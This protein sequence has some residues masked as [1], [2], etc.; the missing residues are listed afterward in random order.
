MAAR[1]GQYCTFFGS[2]LVNKGVGVSPHFFRP[3]NAPLKKVQ[4]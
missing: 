2:V 1:R 3:E 4:D